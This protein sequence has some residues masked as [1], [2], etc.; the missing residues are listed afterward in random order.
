MLRN[1]QDV[2]NKYE[3]TVTHSLLIGLKL[4]G[5][6]LI[7]SVSRNWHFWKFNKKYAYFAL[8]LNDST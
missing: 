4:L 2:S 6:N 5:D 7:M 3:G 8:M 1:K